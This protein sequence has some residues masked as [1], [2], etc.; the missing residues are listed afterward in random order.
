[1]GAKDTDLVEM[2]APAWHGAITMEERTNIERRQKCAAHM[3]RSISH[4]SVLSRHLTW[5]LKKTE[6]KSYGFH[7]WFKPKVCKQNTRQ[8]KTKYFTVKAKHSG[9]EKSP[10]SVLTK[11]LNN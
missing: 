11:N 6:E 1:M 8:E 5:T 4:T 3:G 2:V 7:R 10:I 9:L